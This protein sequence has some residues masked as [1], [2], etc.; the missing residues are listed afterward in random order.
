[1]YV[2]LN[3]HK[4]PRFQRLYTKQAWVVSFTAEKYVNAHA[5]RVLEHVIPIQGRPE[6]ERGV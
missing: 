5:Q 3:E 6:A 1:M 4:T 2:E